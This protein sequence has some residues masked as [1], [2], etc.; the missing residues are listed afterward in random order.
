MLAA[1]NVWRKLL[2]RWTGAESV[3]TRLNIGEAGGDMCDL[4]G[5]AFL[6]E[7]DRIIRSS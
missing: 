4:D 1:L 5:D 7:V 3:D 6:P 2:L